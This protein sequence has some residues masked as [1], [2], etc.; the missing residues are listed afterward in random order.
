METRLAKGKTRNEER[1]MEVPDALCMRNAQ[2]LL[3]LV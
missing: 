2:L 1:M 3:A